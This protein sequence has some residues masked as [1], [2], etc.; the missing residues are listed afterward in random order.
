MGVERIAS[1]VQPMGTQSRGGN[2]RQAMPSA[3]ETL[4]LTFSEAL[5]EDLLTAMSDGRPL[6]LAGLGSLGQKLSE[7]DVLLVRVLSESP[8]LELEVFGTLPRTAASVATAAGWQSEQAAM[9]VDQLVMRQIAWQAPDPAALAAS[10]RALVH[11]RWRSEALRPAGDD[12]LS[13]N[14]Q[15]RTVDPGD[16]DAALPADS[17]R[18]TF[19]VYAWGGLQLMLR[20]VQTDEE[21]EGRPGVLKRMRRPALRVEVRLPGIGRVVMQVR[22]VAGGVELGLATER[23]DA[24]AS[25]RDL[26]PQMAATMAR[27]DLRLVR[28]SFSHGLAREH[29]I[30]RP[31]TPQLGP[32][33]AVPPGL[34]RAAAEV[35]VL[36][37]GVSPTSR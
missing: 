18:W 1:V 13:G 12:P 10:W 35:V 7:G 36:L 14:Y 19:P 16:A 3:G 28:C 24:L 8:Q 9:R 29:E 25:L 30:E 4:Q 26:L 6:R 20:L 22:W 32:A 5:G 31:F 15:P 34:F 17:E 37:A 23:A 11:G 21:E 27:A 2:A 33:S